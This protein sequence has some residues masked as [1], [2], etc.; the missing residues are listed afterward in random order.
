ML[1][2]VVLSCH[3]VASGSTDFSCCCVLESVFRFLL[4]NHSGEKKKKGDCLPIKKTIRNG[5]LV[6]AKP[7][8]SISRLL[9]PGCL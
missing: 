5:I 4:W 2:L 8:S 3:V 1:T 6:I 9:N 7:C